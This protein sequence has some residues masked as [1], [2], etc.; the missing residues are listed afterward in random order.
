MSNNSIKEIVWQIVSSIPKGH[1]A[2]YGQVAAMA[3]YPSHARFVGSVLKNL[4]QNTTLPWFRVINAQG[5]LSF[6]VDSRNYQR[7]R[8]S[9]KSEGV[10]FVGQKISLKEYAWVIKKPLNKSL[11]K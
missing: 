4:P 7:Q 6:P 1:V 9:L 10:V 8:L 3:G 2:S 11:V 5:K